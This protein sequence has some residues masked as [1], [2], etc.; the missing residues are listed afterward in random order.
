MPNRL[1][2]GT[3][4]LATKNGVRFTLFHET[5]G[6]QVYEVDAQVLRTRFGAPDD[7]VDHL[8]TA[9]LAG[10]AEIHDVATAVPGGGHGTVTHLGPEDFGLGG[11]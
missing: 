7:R 11:S 9:Y 10:Q 5:R 1:A 4:P 6:P 2:A 8:L 3:T